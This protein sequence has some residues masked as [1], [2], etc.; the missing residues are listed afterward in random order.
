MSIGR[1]LRIQ[2]RF[3][4]ER[5]RFARARRAR[6]DRLFLEA[7]ISELIEGDFPSVAYS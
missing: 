1:Q 5:L 7:D 2:T 3:S 6:T 4:R